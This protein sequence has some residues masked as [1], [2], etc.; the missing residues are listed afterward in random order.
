MTWNPADEG[1]KED[2][3]DDSSL[4]PRFACQM[5]HLL[6]DSWRNTDIM[7]NRHFQLIAANLPWLQHFVAQLSNPQHPQDKCQVAGKILSSYRVCKI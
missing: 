4:Q 2:A 6:V 3:H 1:D 5:L 7:C